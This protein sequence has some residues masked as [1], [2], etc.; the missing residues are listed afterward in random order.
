MENN[1]CENGK[2]RVFKI[3]T[4]AYDYALFFFFCHK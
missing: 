3:Y 2:N 4:R 1:T